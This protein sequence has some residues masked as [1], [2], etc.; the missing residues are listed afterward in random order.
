MR[1]NDT[2]SGDAKEPDEA[3]R[4]SAARANPMNA[5]RRLAAR[6]TNDADAADYFA[7]RAAAK[8]EMARRLR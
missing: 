4:E 8:Q 7:R 6:P 1:P 2:G 3:L 5:F